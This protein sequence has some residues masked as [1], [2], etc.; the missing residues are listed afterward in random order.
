VFREGRPTLVAAWGCS[1]RPGGQVSAPRRKV[2]ARPTV[3]ARGRLAGADGVV[4]ADL[5]G[6]DDPQSRAQTSGRPGG[7]STQQE[8]PGQTARN[9][10]AGTIARTADANAWS[11]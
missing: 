4:Q 6:K 3:A 2:T 11:R 7:G 10:A 9:R 8:G 5:P 1:A